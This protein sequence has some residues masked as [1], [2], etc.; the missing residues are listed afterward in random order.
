M[1]KEIKKFHVASGVQPIR[2]LSSR[3]PV[4]GEG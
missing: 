1:G 2:A 4:I 3:D